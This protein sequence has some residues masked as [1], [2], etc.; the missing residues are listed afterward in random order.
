MSF[1]IRFATKEDV[2]TILQFI[3]ALYEQLEHEVVKRTLLVLAHRLP[4]TAVG[5]SFS[6]IPLF[7]SSP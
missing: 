5:F 7:L 1:T 4:H 6:I 3:I 2:S